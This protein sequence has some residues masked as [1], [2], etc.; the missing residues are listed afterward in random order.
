MP[1]WR[2]DSTG[3]EVIPLEDLHVLGAVGSSVTNTTNRVPVL[4]LLCGDC[5]GRVNFL[6]PNLAAYESLLSEVKRVGE[7]LLA[8]PPTQ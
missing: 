1:L 6:I 3:P 7:K 2:E 8:N 4:M 5:E